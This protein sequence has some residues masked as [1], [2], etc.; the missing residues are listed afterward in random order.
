M[1]EARPEDAYVDV[2]HEPTLLHSTGPALRVP[3]PLEASPQLGLP[4]G[5]IFFL[6]GVF[7][8]LGFVGSALLMLH[9]AATAP[10]LPLLIL[11]P[12]NAV[13]LFV[14]SGCLTVIV[15][16]AL[17]DRFR[18]QPVVTVRTDGIRDTRVSPNLIPW[19]AVQR[20]SIDTASWVTVSLELRP[21]LSTRHWPF[22]IGAAY[23]W[24]LGT[25]EAQILLMHLSQ[26]P[27][28]LTHVIKSLIEQHGI[29]LATPHHTSPWLSVVLL[30][31]EFLAATWS[32]R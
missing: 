15:L 10:V 5:L 17:I 19:S 2:P 7:G 24:R 6:G 25:S 32:G 14:P 21:G 4:R 27:H 30:P 1:D 22:R 11:L 26:P 9:L 31:F 18:R 12:L 16:T 23:P 13:L 3:L 8:L 29:E 20:A 28:V